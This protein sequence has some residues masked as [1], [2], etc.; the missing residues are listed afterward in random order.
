MWTWGKADDPLQNGWVLSNQVENLGE[1]IE[2]FQGGTLP[3]DSGC[4]I[5]SFLALPCRCG[6]A[7]HSHT[8]KFC[9]SLY[10]HVHIVPPAHTAGS[11]R[12]MQRKMIYL[13]DLGIR[14]TDIVEILKARLVPTF[15]H[16]QKRS[17]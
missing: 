13:R 15:E 16:E 6:L 9:G 3:P 14:T 11:T 4:H 12:V 8:R 5:S 2:V 17:Q 1:K 10:I 7:S